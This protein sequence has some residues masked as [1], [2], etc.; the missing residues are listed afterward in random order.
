MNLVFC[1]NIGGCKGMRRN[2]IPAVNP[3]DSADVANIQ[4]FNTEIAFIYS[5]AT[6]A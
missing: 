5:D 1:Y 6:F 3:H 4:E 2:K